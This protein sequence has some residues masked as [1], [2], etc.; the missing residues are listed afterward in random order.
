MRWGVEPICKVLQVAPSSYY[1]FKSRPPSHRSVTDAELKEQIRRV[2]RHHRSC[3]GAQK[4]WR[5]LQREGICCGRDQVAR[6]MRTLGV[7]GVKRGK[8]KPRTTVPAPE[9]PQDLV[10]RN[11]TASAPDRLWVADLTY[12]AT[13]EGFCYS[14]FVVDCFSRLVVGWAVSESLSATVALDALEMAI[15]RRQGDVEG[16]VHHS[17]RG[18]QYLS[19]RYTERL[20]EAG[21]A[22]SVGS[23][24]DSYDNALAETVN[25]LYKAE[26][27]DRRSWAHARQVE[28]ATASWVEWWNNE[29][30]HGALGYVPPAE[31]ETAA[32]AL[33]ATAAA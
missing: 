7:A 32:R 24:G 8:K 30:L 10:K 22:P 28:L 25:G 21:A 9:H 18:V 11:F 13:R 3:Y 16:V 27:I 2:H 19:I 1:D 12:V 23:K 33:G 26:L 14:A 6:L 4:L 15:W 5:Q 31:Y 17:D 29:R 20:A